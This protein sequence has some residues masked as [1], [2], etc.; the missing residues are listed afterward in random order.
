[1]TD[2]RDAFRALRAT[3]VVT[4]VAILSLALGI[5]ANTAI[6]SIVNAA[7]A[8][9]AAGEGAAAARA[10]HDRT[11]ADVV[12]QPAVG[13][14]CASGEHQLFDGAFAYS[15][16]ALQPRRAAARRSRSNGVMA[17]GGVLRGARRAGDPRPHVHARR[18]TCARAG[19]SDRPVAVISYAFWQRHYGGAA[20]VIGKSARARSR[21]LH[22]HRRHA[23]R[24]SPASTRAAPTTSRSRWP[25][26]ADARRRT[27]ARWTSGRGGGCASW[28][29]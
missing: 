4:A 17:S 9:R 24:S 15:T 25:R 13:S 14:S 12:E 27:K 7:D 19:P 2:L 22:H 3:P 26:A 8:A 18:T 20:D 1:M 21:P 11:A 28:R 10:G 23:A 5:G 29:A 16:P 6:F